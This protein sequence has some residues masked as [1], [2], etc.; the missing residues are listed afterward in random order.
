[1]QGTLISH[2]WN[3][4]DHLR[5]EW[6]FFIVVSIIGINQTLV[7]PVNRAIRVATQPIEGGQEGSSDNGFD[8][9]S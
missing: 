1:M 7:L 2:R 5:K 3:F 8:A 6:L 4:V 9:L